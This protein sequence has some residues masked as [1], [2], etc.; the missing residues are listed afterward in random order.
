MI[1]NL[2]F[3]NPL[4][5]LVAVIII[6]YLAYAFITRYQ[7]ETLGSKPSWA[8]CCDGAV[9]I[10]IKNAT[11]RYHTSKNGNYSTKGGNQSL[12]D[13]IINPEGVEIAIYTNGVLGES[14]KV[15]TTDEYPST[16]GITFW[17]CDSGKSASC[18]KPNSN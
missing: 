15:A 16:E 14:F 6:L 13:E 4:M 2:N 11:G 5:I 12:V 10:N 9:K 18:P 3:K 8:L 7:T 17:W 1:T